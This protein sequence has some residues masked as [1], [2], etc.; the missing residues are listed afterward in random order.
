VRFKGHVTV[1]TGG[2]S[3][4]GRAIALRFAR[5]GSHVAIPDVD[6]AGAT[7][8]AAEVRKLGAE[9]LVIRTDVS[10]SEEVQVCLQTVLQRFQKIDILVNNAG[11]NIARPLEEF[12]DADWHRIVGINLNGVWFFC[13]Y[14]IPHFLQRG[15]GVIVNIASIGAF[16]AS[17]DRAPYMA[18]K[19][20]VVS[21]TQSLALDFADRNIR[22]NAI[23]PGVVETAMGIRWR[24]NPANRRSVTFL[25]PMGRF[26]QPDEIAA[27][28]AFLASDDASFITGH[29]LCVDG[30]LLAGNRFGRQELWEAAPT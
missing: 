8:T 19:G 26:G 11:I 25:T 13:R 21:L 22:V 7:Q 3:G 24:A 16:Q 5:E 17:H 20:G 6:E 29:T 2:G 23:A 30:G 27:A 9:A 4:I 10:K 18:S 28:A 15:G 12:S 14:T 1:V